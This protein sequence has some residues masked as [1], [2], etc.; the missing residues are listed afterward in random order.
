MNA[1]DD[2]YS[3]DGPF[4]TLWNAVAETSQRITDHICGLR[5]DESISLANCVEAFRAA[6]SRCQIAM[7]PEVLAIEFARF[8]QGPFTQRAG[9][10]FLD[11][12]CHVWQRLADNAAALTSYLTISDNPW[13]EDGLPPRPWLAMP[14]MMRGHIT[15]LHGPGSAGK[16]MLVIIWSIALALGKPFGRLKPKQRCRV[17]LTNFEDDAEE[18]MRRISAALRYFNA[19]PADLKG[20]LYRVSIG[21]NGDATMFELDENGQVQG[22]PCWKALEHACEM[23]KPDAVALDP[24]VAINAVPEKDN[25][26]APRDDH[27]AVAVRDSF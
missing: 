22:T 26:L 11:D 14:H 16:S 13:D 6:A 2:Q 25:Q 20:W 24:L 10:L 8:P 23:I 19:T 27:H 12:V 15:L 3:G 1:P 7:V 9:K 4:Q 18:Q 5:I 17:L 21:P